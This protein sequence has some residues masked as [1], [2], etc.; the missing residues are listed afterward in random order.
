[1]ADF[2]P[3]ICEYSTGLVLLEAPL[4][5]SSAPCWL[6]TASHIPTHPL[7]V[8]G[9]IVVQ[10][11]DALG[12]LEELA[13]GGI[14]PPVHQVAVAIVL[15]TCETISRGTERALPVQRL[16]LEVQPGSPSS[17]SPKSSFS[18]LRAG[19][20]LFLNLVDDPK[21]SSAPANRRRAPAHWE[22]LLHKKPTE[23]ERVRWPTS[24]SFQW[25]V[26]LE[27]FPVELCVSFGPIVSPLG[28]KWGVL[29]G[30]GWWW[31]WCLDR[32]WWGGG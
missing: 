11:H 17:G 24:Q 29:Q 32:G 15:A 31:W 20:V 18:P 12:L 22:V 5:G 28:L 21:G 14:G 27:N 8:D 4:R 13:V 26:V 2:Q 25:T 10:V 23:R 7:I 19:L 30:A 3:C 1:M 9:E 16:V 6:N